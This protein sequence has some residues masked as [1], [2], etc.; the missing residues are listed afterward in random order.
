MSLSGDL[1]LGMTTDMRRRVEIARM[2]ADVA[3]FEAR[4]ELIGEPAT[5][6]QQAQRKA[7]AHLCESLASQIAEQREEASASGAFSIEG[8]FDS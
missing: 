1:A 6:N 7:F 5:T 3:Y 2:E 8:L 4:L